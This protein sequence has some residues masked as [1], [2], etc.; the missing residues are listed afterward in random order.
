LLVELLLDF[1]WPLE[2]GRGVEPYSFVHLFAI[3]GLVAHKYRL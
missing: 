2:A 3:A 1:D